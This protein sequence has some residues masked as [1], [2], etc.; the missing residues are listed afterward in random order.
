MSPFVKENLEEDFEETNEKFEGGVDT[1]GK[2]G[3]KTKPSIS[4]EFQSIV[5]S[6]FDTIR[7]FWD[8]ER[9]L[10]RVPGLFNKPV[11]AAL[12]QEQGKLLVNLLLQIL[13]IGFPDLVKHLVQVL[14]NPLLRLQK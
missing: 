7:I 3:D 6:V 10:P 11:S 9:P 12:A 14:I 1:A 13:W 5:I 4:Q 8:P 2:T